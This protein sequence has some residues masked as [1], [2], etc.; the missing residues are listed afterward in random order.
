VRTTPG[1]EVV[2]DNEILTFGSS[3]EYMRQVDFF[4]KDVVILSPVH[5]QQM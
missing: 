4:E 3:E 5:V 1:T 2:S